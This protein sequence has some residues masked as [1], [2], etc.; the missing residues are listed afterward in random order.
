MKKKP[1]NFLHERQVL[2]P[3]KETLFDVKQQD[4]KLKKKNIFGFK[5]D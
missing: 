5:F 2:D 4:K 1:L 3:P